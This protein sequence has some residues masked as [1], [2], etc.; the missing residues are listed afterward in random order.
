MNGVSVFRVVLGIL[1]GLL[2]AGGVLLAFTGGGFDLF[3]A[4]VWLIG[5]GIFLL[6]VSILEISRYRSQPA[7]DARLPPGPGGGEPE[8]IEPRF[9]PTGEVFI[10]PTTHRRMRVFADPNT[11]ERRYVA[12]G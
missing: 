5:A 10:D 2:V 7:E 11:G 12:E 4:V 6:I 1:G 8:P 3:P 9:R